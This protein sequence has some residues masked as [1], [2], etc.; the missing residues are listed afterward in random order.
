[1]HRRVLA[2]AA[3]LAWALLGTGLV[4][5]RA[6][7]SWQEAH[8]AG[9][10]AQ[11]HIEPNGYATVEHAVRWR[12]V[13]GPL[14][15]IDL[16]NVDGAAVVEPVVAIQ[17]DDGKSLTGH[18]SRPDG[19]TV[20]VVVDDPR[21]TL[22]GT[23]T[24]TIRWRIDLVAAGAFA[25]DGATWRL[26]IVQ[27]TATEGFDGARTVVD[28]PASPDAPQPIRAD[29]GA[30]DEGAVAS[31]RRAGA[32]DVLELVRPHVARGEAVEWTVRVDPRALSAVPMQPPPSMSD[33]PRVSRDPDRIGG[34]ALVVCTGALG[35]A[36]GALVRH[37]GRPLGAGSASLAAAAG[38]LLPLPLT[39]RSVVSGAA[40]AIGVG[41]Q[42]SDE[43]YA[44]SVCVAI[45]ILAAATRPLATRPVARGPGRW[46]VLRPSDAFAREA[47]PRD[48][49]DPATPP[50]R[51]TALLV[52]LGVVLLAL[53]SR[54]L[55]PDGPWLVGM[56]AVV[57]IPPFMTVPVG[58]RPFHGSRRGTSWLARGYRRLC[59]LELLRVA[60]WARVALDGSIDELRL[61]VLPRAAMPGLIGIEMGLAGCSAPAGWGT[62][63]EILVRVLESTPAC[64]KLI[65][66]L[67]ALRILP[68][69][70]PDE[71]V[72]RVVPHRPSSRASVSLIA[73]LARLLTDRRVS[74]PTLPWPGDNRRAAPPGRP[75][76]TREHSAPG[77]SLC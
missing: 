55:A 44:G 12:V 75:A 50:G 65:E 11:L 72:A 34:C 28:L 5:M 66:L 46:L 14:K 26:R 23:F 43:L 18:V 37:K 8:L 41:L 40:L 70:R 10:D 19:S 35:L 57:L 56:D 69:R 62:A 59:G 2:A 24:F 48:W 30:V 20:R 32:R 27:P 15:S 39:I 49:L 53:A 45:A 36:F 52:S 76:A 33:G 4:A 21:A 68:G 47:P 38:A 63:P 9:D 42:A 25:R 61:L 64:T 1:M 54:R 7:A 73:E 71:R 77:P 60:P 67:P 22:R 16:G 51:V 29:T 58:P 74:D 17:S 3:A 13:H 31:V 6:D